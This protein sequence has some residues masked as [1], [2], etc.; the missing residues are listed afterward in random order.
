[1]QEKM[2]KEIQQVKESMALQLKDLETQ[3]DREI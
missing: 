3:K 1:M 2:Q